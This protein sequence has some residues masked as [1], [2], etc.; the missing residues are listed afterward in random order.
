[1]PFF[2]YSL[3]SSALY[4]EVKFFASGLRLRGSYL[5]F[6]HFENLST[7]PFLIQNTS[8]VYSRGLAYT[9]YVQYFDLFF[10]NP[11]LFII[12]PSDIITENYKKCYIVLENFLVDTIKSTERAIKTIPKTIVYLDGSM[13]K[14]GLR[15]TVGTDIL[16]ILSK[17]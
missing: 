13:T 2:I 3:K 8:S 4:L 17:I 1:M 9:Q 12:S 11:S 10:S 15:D 14:E 16:K 5:Y 7:K 6:R